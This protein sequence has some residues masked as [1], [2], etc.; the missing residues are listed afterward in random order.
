MLTLKR[1]FP[2]VRKDDRISYGGNQMWAQKALIRDVGCG[3]VAAMDLLR[4]LG[5]E[6]QTPLPL[7]EYN[8]E[9]EELCRRYF[10]LI[11]YSGINGITLAIGVNR[12]FRLRKLPFHAVW[13]FS[14]DRLW[15]RAAEM[16]SQDLPVI[17]SIGPNFPLVWRKD[18]LPFYVRRHDGS[19]IPVSSAK[20]HYVSVTGLDEDWARISS[21]GREF[22]LSQREY[23]DFVRKHSTSLFSN[24]LYIKRTDR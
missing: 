13:A 6:C 19:M 7:A 23:D 10:P 11:P 21:W 5:G 3:P 14:G 16:L 24:I 1:S 9:L 18:R 2:R 8:R 20:S 22:Y 15:D 4:Y 12:L 17:L